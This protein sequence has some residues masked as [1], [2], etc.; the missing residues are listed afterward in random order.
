MTPACFQLRRNFLFLPLLLLLLK[1]KC[2]EKS[3]VSVYPSEYGSFII[4]DIAHCER[5]FDWKE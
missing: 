4:Y 5:H 3:S 2:F 1:G